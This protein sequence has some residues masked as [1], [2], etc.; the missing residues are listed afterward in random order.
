MKRRFLWMPAAIL[1]LCGLMMT[2]CAESDNA[3]SYSG[4]TANTED[5][6]DNTLPTEDQASVVVN[7]DIKACVPVAFE[8]GST[9]E[10]LVKRLASTTTEVTPDTRLLLV[11]GSVFTSETMD[12]TLYS[13]I[14]SILKSGGYVAVERLK[15][16]QV[17]AFSVVMIM[18]SVAAQMQLYTETFIDMTEEEASRAAQQSEL[19]SRMRARSVNLENLNRSRA[20][21][22]NPQDP[23]AEMII[24]GMK[25]YFV[26]APLLEEETAYV[27]SDDNEGNVTEEEEVTFKRQERTPYISGQ[28]ADAAAKWL[29]EE[30]EE[31]KAAKSSLSRSF[32]RADNPDAINEMIGASE[33]LTYNAPITWTDNE[34]IWHNVD[35]RANMTI[36]SWG[37]H[38][39]ETNEDYYY[40]K[41][42]ITLN[43]GERD[44]YKIY[45]PTQ[46][47]DWWKDAFNYK[48][49]YNRWF[50]SFMANYYTSMNLSG[51]GNIKLELAS[52]VTD[53][54]SAQVSLGDET[55][56]S[57]EV[58]I[59]LSFGGSADGPSFGED[60][61]YG[62][63]KGRT[64]TFQ[65]TT[66]S[67]EWALTKNTNGTKVNWTY[68]GD[69]PKFWI[70]EDNGFWEDRWWYCHTFPHPILVNDI[71]MEH[72]ICWSVANPSGQYTLNVTSCPET[73]AIV[74]KYEKNGKKA[75]PNETLYTRGVTQQYTHQLLEPN[76]AMQ[77]WHMMV[78]IEPKYAS[79][80]VKGVSELIAT[81]L[82][83]NFKDEY[84][85]EFTVADKT[86]D[87]RNTITSIIN[88]SK[89]EFAENIEILRGH[90][91]S[92]DIKSFTIWWMYKGNKVAFYEV[93]NQ[94]LIATAGTQS[95]D[96]EGWKCLV[97]GLTTTKWYTNQKKDG[98]YFVE[99]KST[100]PGYPVSVNLTTANDAASYWKRNP[101]NWKLMG[102]SMTTGNWDTL[103][104]VVNDTKLP[105]AN[106]KTAEYACDAQFTSNQYQQFRF[107]VS[108]TQGDSGVQLSEVGIRFKE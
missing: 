52:P 41:Q 67:K 81:A 4:G 84:Q 19:A 51:S 88:R 90:L 8:G 62:F 63:S 93:G 103:V 83:Q 53:N 28:L 27:Y 60:F 89:R 92:Y 70:K 3:V 14:I 100:Q 58:S 86:A 10:A 66:E 5:A 17:G 99:F 32:R 21:D 94:T 13:G 59:G 11:P 30:E 16:E 61:S 38:C 35:N 54:N 71:D 80:D 105:H 44:G 9:G 23:Y 46:G 7:S 85:P 75:A 96:F 76:R 56:Y 107:E 6:P 77:D 25:D 78:T 42:R 108:E 74:Y 37:V 64:F 73:A 104:E 39:M 72:E 34:N 33:K 57:D 55:S 50:G 95:K 101:K 24:F 36:L 102:K 43:M 69:L 91:E 65:T 106:Y 49:G 47:E 29:N 20:A 97:D 2:S 40:M 45:W 31:A 87:A 82:V 1:L 79:Q 12:Q 26:Q 18:A 15:N 68:K 48:N 98:V 22:I